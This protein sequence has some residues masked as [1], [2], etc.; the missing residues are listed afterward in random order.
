[1][2]RR[3]MAVC[4]SNLARVDGGDDTCWIRGFSSISS[5][6]MRLGRRRPPHQPPTDT[7]SPNFEDLSDSLNSEFDPIGD[8]TTFRAPLGRSATHQKQH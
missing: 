2:E 4:S 1:M 5:Q 8:I 3:R 6:R 7:P